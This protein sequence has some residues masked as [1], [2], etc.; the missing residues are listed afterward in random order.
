MLCVSAKEIRSI[1]R[2][3]FEIWTEK[4]KLLG[5]LRYCIHGYAVTISLRNYKK[6][7]KDI[8]RKIKIVENDNQK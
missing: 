5:L 8:E 2:R 7:C 4:S 1:S 6:R 3:N